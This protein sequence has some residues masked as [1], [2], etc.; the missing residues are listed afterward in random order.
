MKKSNKQSLKK[1]NFKR[2]FLLNTSNLDAYTFTP[3]I[4]K[5]SVELAKK[6]YKNPITVFDR[7]FNQVFLK[8]VD[9]Y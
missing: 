5:M 8:Y 6:K 9:V 7:L 4:D 1:L 3:K 2:S